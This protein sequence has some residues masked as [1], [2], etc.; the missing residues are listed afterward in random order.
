MRPAKNLGASVRARL[1]R[2]AREQGADFQLVLTRYANERLLYRLA[3][4]PHATQF[5]L[6]GA[7]LFTLWTGR[8]HRATRDLDLLGFGPPVPRRLQSI[9]REVVTLEVVDD[10]VQFDSK[11]IQVEPI[12][13][14]QDYGGVR[15]GIV[16]R[17]SSAEVRLQ[18]DVGFGDAITPE[19]KQ[20]EFPVLLDS[21]RPRL[22][23]YPQETVVAEKIEAAVHLGLANSR[24]K[25]FY[26]LVVLSQMFE[27]DG[28]LLARAIRATFDRRGTMLPK[29]LPP[30][31]TPAF[32]E[33]AGKKA[34]WAAFM[35]K[36]AAA[37]VG[38]L[39]AAMGLVV[40]FLQAPL[41]AAAGATPFTAQWTKGG[42]WT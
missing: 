8:P 31:L 4:S 3:Q 14:D 9:F 10:G 2:L 7:A 24:M 40:M 21:P 25:D 15:I 29:D 5:V 30:A 13:E 32:Y 26:D 11:L 18:V 6:K 38:D 41:A 22:R 33:D 17:I 23:A 1:L 20:V 34:D 28:A 12:R 36:A 37:N 19:T 42:P 35:R 39:P 27:F 16:A